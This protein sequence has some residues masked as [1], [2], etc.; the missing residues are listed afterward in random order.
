VAWNRALTG[1]PV[2]AYSALEWS[3]PAM[4][5]ATRQLALVSGSDRAAAFAAISD[6]V[7]AVTIVDAAM[8]RYYHDVYD[9]VLAAE[10]SAEPSRSL[11]PSRS[12][13]ARRGGWPRS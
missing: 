6:A 8:V 12:S 10:T 5:G 13:T 7:W 11:S 2:V 1:D 3:V 9:R 4:R